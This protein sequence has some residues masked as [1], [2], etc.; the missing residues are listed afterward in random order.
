M[1]ETSHQIAVGNRACLQYFSLVEFQS[2]AQVRLGAGSTTV[3]FYEVEIENLHDL[4]NR[5]IHHRIIV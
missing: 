5:V 2:A 4:V 1:I 3:A